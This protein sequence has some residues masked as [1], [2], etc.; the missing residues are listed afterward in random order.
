MSYCSLDPEPSVSTNFTTSAILF[1]KNKLFLPSS[2]M[3]E[4]VFAIDN[5]NDIERFGLYERL[6]SD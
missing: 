2:K 1:R 5:F 3:F 4:I 6:Q